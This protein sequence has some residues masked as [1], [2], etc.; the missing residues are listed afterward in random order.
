MDIQYVLFD[1]AGT[2]LHKPEFYKTLQKVLNDCGYDFE[3]EEL[4]LK[5]KILSEV[6]HFPDRTNKDFYQEFNRELL[7]SLGIV[8]DEKMLDEVFSKCSYLPWEQCKD[9]DFLSSIPV[10]MGV[11]SNFNSTLKEKLNGFFGP[12]FKDVFVSEELGVS[13]PDLEFYKRAVEKINIKAEN[14]LY[15]GDSLK[16]DIE[17]ALK[18][19]MKPLLIDREGFFKKSDY[20]IENLNQL[21]NYLHL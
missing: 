16:L 6:I 21:F 20:Q 9:A 13:K 1:V 3:L 19:G 11:L 5:H 15:I 12:V 14:I 10:P 17:P 7:F 8:P 2:L 4:K 18:I